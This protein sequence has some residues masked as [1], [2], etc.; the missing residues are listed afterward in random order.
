MSLTVIWIITGLLM[1]AGLVCSALPSLPGLAVILGAAYLF[2]FLTDFA[3]VGWSILITLTVITVLM[4]VVDYLAGAWG[5]KKLGGSRSGIIGSLIGTILGLILLNIPGMILGAFLGAALAE[6]IVAKQDLRSSMK[7]G[8]GSL[9]GL[10]AG[11][12]MRVVVGICMIVIFLVAG[13]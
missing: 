6:L 2:A 8:L 10:L 4:Q 1:L 13:I 7:I 12:L 3:Q 9:V 11:T 5:V